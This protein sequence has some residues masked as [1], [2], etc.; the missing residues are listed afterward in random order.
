[1]S[2]AK[3]KEGIKS[4]RKEFIEGLKKHERMAERQFVF[5]LYADVD[6]IFEYRIDRNKIHDSS[7]KF[8]YSLLEHMIFKKG[9]KSIDDI[10]VEAYVDSQKKSVREKYDTCGGYDT[11]VEFLQIIEPENIS[12]FYQ[13][14]LKY[15]AVSRLIEN[16]FDVYSSRKEINNMSYEQ[17]SVK[18][19]GIIDNIFQGDTKEEKVVDIKAGIRQMIKDSNEGVTRGLPLFSKMLNATVNGMALGNIT[20][21]AGASGSFKTGV[22]LNQVLPAMINSKEKL[23]IMC[24]EEDINK[25][26]QDL[27]TWHINNI[28]K[29][30]FVKSRFH[31]GTF[32]KQ[33]LRM[34]DTAV[35]WMEKECAD[36]LITFVSFNTFSMDKSIR[37]MRRAIVQD[38]VKYFIIDTLKLDNDIGSKI[39]EQSWLQLQQN[40]VKLYNVI[41]PSAYNCH[42][43]VT[44][45]LNKSQKTRFLDQTSLG[46]SKNVADVVST[47][48]L[49]RD[50][51]K[52]EKGTQGITVQQKH[53][54]EQKTTFLNEKDN[55]MV[56]FIDKNRRGS[57][58][59]QIVFKVDKGRNI[60][61]G[62]G[63]TRIAQDY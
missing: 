36:G 61:K 24:N 22:T 35:E 39:N 20:M 21:V 7:T 5:S 19:E 29:G 45:Q 27:I 46:M 40:M 4:D 58:E 26:Q 13:E 2:E 43:W 63:F 18:M 55:Y 59:N 49:I 52:N 41:K 53:G 28:Q 11:V 44:Y 37:M 1:M 14:V 9:Y 33:E 34:M 3:A 8:Y 25:W 6:L 23:L 50:V 60:M 57:I 12:T 56:M 42:V 32:S 54:D 62:A 47:L 48:I 51:L 15:D 16:G 30:D 38:D 17:L 10:T 31:Q